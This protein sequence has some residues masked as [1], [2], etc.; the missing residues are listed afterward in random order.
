MK[1]HLKE[2]GSLI[3]V[4]SD[5]HANFNALQRLLKKIEFRPDDHLICLGDTI[6][7]GDAPLETIYFFKNNIH[8]N[9]YCLKGNHE[10]MFIDYYRYKRLG[11]ETTLPYNTV[12]ILEERITPVDIDEIVEWMSN[13]PLQKVIELN[14]QV[15]VLAHGQTHYNESETEFVVEDFVLP[16]EEFYK[17]RILDNSFTQDFISVVG[18]CTTSWLSR[19]SPSIIPGKIFHNQSGNTYFIDCGSGYSDMKSSCLA[20]LRLDD[21]AEFY[22][23]V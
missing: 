19:Y 6:D 10:Q 23:E 3:Y 9:L 15:F 1:R 12:G 13:L 5:V 4:V 22:V 17:T 14:G 18:H 11:F 21:M 8:N 16:D 2:G 20:A 7:R